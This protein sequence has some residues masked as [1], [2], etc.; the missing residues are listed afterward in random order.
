MW[1]AFA[2]GQRSTLPT[3]RHRPQEGMTATRLTSL[4]LAS[5]TTYR[6]LP[7]A[8]GLHYPRREIEEG[9]PME[10]TDAVC[11]LEITNAACRIP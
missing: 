2:F 3:F 11:G 1:A 6:Q 8:R 9:S 10:L 7:L 4:A 5:P